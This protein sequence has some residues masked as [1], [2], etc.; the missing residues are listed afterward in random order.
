VQPELS[1]VVIDDGSQI[2]APRG[3]QRLNRL[4]H[5]DRQPLYVADPLEIPIIRLLRRRNALLS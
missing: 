5:F 4:Q 1:R 2:L 3:V